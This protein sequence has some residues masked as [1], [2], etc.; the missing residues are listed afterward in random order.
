MLEAYRYITAK[1]LYTYS[2]ISLFRPLLLDTHDWS[3][4]FDFNVNGTH[5]RDRL[6]IKTILGF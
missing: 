5:F 2:K 6:A 1:Y 4:T 3:Q